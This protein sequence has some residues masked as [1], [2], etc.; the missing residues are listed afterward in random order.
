MRCATMAGAVLAL[1]LVAGCGS[2]DGNGNGNGN[3][4]A[5]QEP[6]PVRVE[7]RSA[8]GD[9]AGTVEL[10]ERAGGT[11]IRAQVRGLEPGFHGFHVHQTGVCDAQAVKE[12]EPAPFSSAEGHY[13]G[14]GD[15]SHGDHAGDLPTL[16]AGDDG[17][18]TLTTLTD[19]FEIGDLRDAD[20]SAIM[21]HALRD[22]QANIPGRY[23]IE[24]EPGPDSDTQDTGDSGDRVACGLVER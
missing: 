10:T 9:P 22:N 24:G 5:S 19:R 1:T 8:K 15:A 14:D 7:L 4:Q 2:G 16:L 17:T 20:G 11:E 21:V 12:G 18:A 6:A 3:G 23:K 13:A